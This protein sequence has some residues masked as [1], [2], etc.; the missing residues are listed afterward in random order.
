MLAV[1]FV[2][3]FHIIHASNTV[4]TSGNYT[5]PDNGGTC[6]I[7]CDTREAAHYATIDCGNANDCYYNCNAESCNEYGE[8]KAE[9]VTNLYITQGSNAD[10]CLKDTTIYTPNMQ[11]NNHI[12]LSKPYKAT[13]SK[14][15][16]LKTLS[17][18]Q[19][20]QPM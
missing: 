18:L 2:N 1:Y 3:L 4:L 19:I 20:H 15:E 12:I 9:N 13:Q 5:C 7:T 17:Y 6:T 8:L 16:L 10:E 14:E 11:C